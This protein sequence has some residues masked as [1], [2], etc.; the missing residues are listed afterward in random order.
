MASGGGE[1]LASGGGELRV[2]RSLWR[3]LREAE[4]ERESGERRAERKVREA[5]ERER[6]KKRR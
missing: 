4:I 1:L 2:E 6:K 5:D 3:I